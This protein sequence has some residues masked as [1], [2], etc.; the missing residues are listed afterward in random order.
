[1]NLNLASGEHPTSLKGWVNVDLPWDGVKP[2]HVYGDAFH[3]PFATRSFERAYL[4]HF[5]EHVRWRAIPAMLIELR[6]VL[7]PKAPIMV[8]GPALDRALRQCEPEW[9]CD[10][11]VGEGEGPGAHKWVPTEE[12]HSL[13]LLAGGLED[14]RIVDV[15]DIKP[16]IWPNPVPQATWQCALAATTP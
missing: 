8:V 6:R 13:A 12:L 10:A 2:P 15:R 5:I 9:L 3:L 14:V 4:G 11:I 1:M 16:P 7:T